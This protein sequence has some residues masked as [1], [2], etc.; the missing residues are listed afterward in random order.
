MIDS[1]RLLNIAFGGPQTY[2]FCLNGKG[3]AWEGEN[4]LLEAWLFIR[5]VMKTI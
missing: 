5:R 4:E 2:K 1:R 3:L